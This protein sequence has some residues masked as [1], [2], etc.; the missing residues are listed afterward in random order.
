MGLAIR[1]VG[2]LLR[3]RFCDPAKE[4]LNPVRNIAGIIFFQPDLVANW[5]K[6]ELSAEGEGHDFNA[7]LRE[8]FS[9]TILPYFL[10]VFDRA[11]MAYGLESCTP[12]LDHRL[13]EFVF[14]LPK[15]D[16]VGRLCKRIL[17]QAGRE[18]PPEKVLRRGKIPFTAPVEINHL[19][20]CF[21]PIFNRNVPL[22]F[23]PTGD[24]G[25]DMS[26]YRVACCGHIYVDNQK[27]QNSKCQGEMDYGD[28]SQ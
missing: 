19:L 24:H 20:I 15:R 22:H 17:R 16:K 7:S 25:L 18:W 2:S 28:R 8:A 11:T 6:P 27:N 26:E 3:Q 14:S 21:F 10:S 12:F 13:V 5:E 9:D 23:S 1:D 4:R